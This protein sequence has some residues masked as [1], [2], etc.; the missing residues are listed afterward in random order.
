MHS[1]FYE[2]SLFLF[3]PFVSLCLCLLW[4]ALLI[5]TAAEAYTDEDEGKEGGEVSEAELFS[6]ENR[7]LHVKDFL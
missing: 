2:C 1:F 5:W 4:L 6:R 7:S 3:F